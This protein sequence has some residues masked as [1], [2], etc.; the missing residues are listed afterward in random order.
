MTPAAMA[1][2]ILVTE[3]SSF[4]RFVASFPPRV[5]VSSPMGGAGLED[6]CLDCLSDEYEAAGRV[7]VVFDK[8]NSESLANVI[9]IA[10][11]E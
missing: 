11:G 4:G 8:S 1:S 10:P 9:S 7:V 6:D 5:I 2:R 3:S